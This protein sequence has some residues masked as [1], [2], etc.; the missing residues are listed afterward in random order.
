[1]R[2]ILVDHARKH[3]AEKRGS[4]DKPVTLEE[5]LVSSDK[6][7]DLIALD[8]ALEALA[9]QDARKTRVLE[10]HYF[11]GLTQEEIAT[12]LDVHVNTVAR[13]MKLAQAWIH[14]HMRDVT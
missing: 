12:V 11:G 6:S 14:R 8:D 13:D 9:K 3:A 10:L 4:G 1:M 2:Q 7:S 5:E